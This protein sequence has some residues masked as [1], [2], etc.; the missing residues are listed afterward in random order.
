[1]ILTPVIYFILTSER[2]LM[3]QLPLYPDIHLAVFC[4]GVIATAA[5]FLANFLL[6]VLA[7]PISERSRE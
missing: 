6:Y 1:M 5:L 4:I 3:K 7:E 2:L